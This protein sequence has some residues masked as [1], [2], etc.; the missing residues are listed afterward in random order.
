MFEMPA[1]EQYRLRPFIF[2]VKRDC[3]FV[4]ECVDNCHRFR[5][6]C[7]NSPNSAGSRT[8]IEISNFL[9]NQ[10]LFERFKQHRLSVKTDVWVCLVSDYGS[11]DRSVS[12]DTPTPKVA[13]L[14]QLWNRNAS[15]FRDDAATL[16][17]V[18]ELVRANAPV[19][20]ITIMDDDPTFV[21]SFGRVVP[22][23]VR[24]FA[25]SAQ[26]LE[27]VE[28]FDSESAYEGCFTVSVP[29]NTSVGEQEAHPI[30]TLRG[31]FIEHS[32][33]ESAGAWSAGFQIDTAFAED[34]VDGRL[35]D[36]EFIS[37]RFDCGSAETHLSN[38]VALCLIEHS[39]RITRRCALPFQDVV[40][41]HTV[42]FEFDSQYVGRFP[43]LIPVDD[44][45]FLLRR[46][47]THSSLSID[48]SPPKHVVER[49]FGDAT[50]G[51]DCRHAFIGSVAANDFLYLFFIERRSV[52]AGD[53]MSS[54]DFVYSCGRQP[55]RR[56]DCQN[57][58]SVFVAINDNLISF[59]V[60]GSRH[61]SIIEQ[62]MLEVNSK[63]FDNEAFYA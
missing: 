6:G 47:F 19:D 21:T 25:K 11:T 53:I 20:V 14:S 62:S 34:V 10:K 9:I 29:M 24:R 28:I 61:L 51:D 30:E 2:A 43:S 42:Y 49:A 16:E 55:Q 56:G 60:G 1:I 32:L 50:C 17:C 40:D 38:D 4:V 54:Y 15:P 5:S 45:D 31:Q 37:N 12:V 18:A 46:R 27:V 33:V 35:S 57:Q 59:F 58:F 13:R 44:V 7:L 63:T 3:C 48:T 36:I 52:A 22:D 26:F 8:Q 41:C 23:L 39:G